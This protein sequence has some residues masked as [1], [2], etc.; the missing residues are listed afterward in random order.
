MNP[1]ILYLFFVSKR[2]GG[3]EVQKKRKERK[4]THIY[5]HQYTRRHAH[6]QTLQQQHTHTHTHSHIPIFCSSVKI[7]AFCRSGPL[8]RFFTNHKMFLEPLHNCYART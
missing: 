3:E 7:P 1:H 2:L 4:Y 5:T 8:T 6:T